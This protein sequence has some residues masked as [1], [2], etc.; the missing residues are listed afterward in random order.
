MRNIIARRIHTDTHPHIIVP[1]NIMHEDAIFTVAGDDAQIVSL[2]QVADDEIVP[3]DRLINGSA[4][5]IVM[6]RGWPYC[7]GFPC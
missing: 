6:A 7:V 1:G 3:S 5:A 4:E 2:N